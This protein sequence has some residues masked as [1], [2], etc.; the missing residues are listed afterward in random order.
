MR[1]GRLKHRVVLQR[2]AETQNAIG[3]V[4]WSYEDVATVWAS[5]EPLQGREFFGAAQVQS[6]VTTRIR[7]RYRAGVNTKMRAVHVAQDGSPTLYDF[8]DIQAVIEPHRAR[9][10]LQLMCVKRDAEGFRHDGNA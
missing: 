6:D 8:Y 7:I 10:E 3:E 4:V 1:A 9:R 5:V 2:R